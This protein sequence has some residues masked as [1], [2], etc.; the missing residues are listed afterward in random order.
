MTSNEYSFLSSTVVKE[1][2]TFK[3]DISK[4]VPKHVKEAVEAKYE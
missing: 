2:A 4:I 1:I 3:G